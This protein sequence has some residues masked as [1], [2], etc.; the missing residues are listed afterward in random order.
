MTEIT[1]L[2]KKKTN[3]VAQ[4]LLGQLLIHETPLGPIGGLI[5]DTESYLGP[6]DR[7]SHSYGGKR[8]PSLRAM[9]QKP[10]TI[11]VYQMHTHLLLNL[12]TE[13][14][15]QPEGVMIR[16]IEPMI[17][18]PLMEE[19]RHQQGIHLTNGPGKLTQALHLT[20]DIYGTSIFTGPLKVLAT[21]Y[22]A[23]EIVRAPRIGIP[24]KGIWTD[25][26]LRYYVKGNPF[27]TKIKKNEVDQKDHG[28]KGSRV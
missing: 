17:G 13:P 26:P 18:L 23:K 10:G 24:N 20:R 7:A 1:E 6:T 14:C 21:E 22:Q 28:W 5:V 25:L 4:G 11:Y 8:T 16:A 19:L 12:V 2:F 3:D 27:T 15:G 9:Y